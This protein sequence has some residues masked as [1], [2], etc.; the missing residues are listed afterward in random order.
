MDNFLQPLWRIKQGREVTDGEWET[1]RW[2]G[3]VIV[4]RLLAPPPWK[5]GFFQH[6]GFPLPSTSQQTL[7]EALPCPSSHPYSKT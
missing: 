3:A 1:C 7:F 2:E 6:V 4:P 5:L